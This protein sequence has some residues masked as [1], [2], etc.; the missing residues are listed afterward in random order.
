MT[1]RKD[2]IRLGAFLM[3]T[4]HHVAAWR[5]PAAQADAGVNLRHYIEI[6]QAAERARFDMVFLADSQGGFFDRND[7]RS[8]SYASQGA[9]FEPLTLLSALAAHT[10]HIGL[11]ATATTTYYPPFILARL[12]A[13][14]DILSGGRAAWNLVTSASPLE[15]QNFGSAQHPEPEERYERAEEFVD[16]VKGLWESWE[17]DAF[18]RDKVTGRFS[19]TDKLHILNHVGRHFSV[20]GPLNVP[21]SAQ[22]H[23][24]IVQAGSSEPG[25]NLA[26][27]T[28]EAVFTAHQTIESAQAFYADLKARMPAYGRNPE[29]LKVMPGVFP[30]IGSS[31]AE[32][33]AKYEALSDL[34]HPAIP[35][36]FLAS[37]F[38]DPRL[39]DHPIDEPLPD[40][41][42]VDG[43]ASRPAL[44][45]DIARRENLTV[46]QLHLH[47]AGARG[48]RT[49]FGTPESIADQ[50]EHWFDGYAADGFNIMP[51]YLP[52][53]LTEFIDQVIPILQQ[54]GRFRTDYAGPTLRENLDLPFPT[55]PA[56]AQISE[57]AE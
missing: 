51:P 27:R 19:D 10:S 17:D 22:G 2:Q 37:V 49:I 4:G 50:L 29:T 55:H 5:H 25:R 36:R 7:R 32:A 26:A 28:A 14:L 1:K 24:V 57:A 54:R 48:H 3:A 13:S 11:V 8:V 45:L 6:A 56:L 35:R 46:R 43:R 38:N 23:P 40:W 39:L 12:F 21:R 42:T 34:I 16:V 52:D 31:E 30:V 18:P 20:A 41:L 33:R 9:T 53:G 15:A 44:L 47:V